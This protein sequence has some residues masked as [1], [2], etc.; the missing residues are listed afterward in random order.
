LLHPGEGRKAIPGDQTL[1]TET[2]FPAV[3]SG[4]PAMPEDLPTM[5]GILPTMLEEAI[6]TLG[7]RKPPE[8]VQ[9]VIAELRGVREMFGPH[10]QMF[11]VRGQM[12]GAELRTLGYYRV[13]FSPARL[14]YLLRRI[15]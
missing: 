5:P 9:Q 6:Q 15:P 11:G 2:I 12:F 1:L 8:R 7:Q 13:Y 3:D 4:V 10:R 14:H